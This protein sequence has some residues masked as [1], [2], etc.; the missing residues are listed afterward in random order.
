MSSTEHKNNDDTQECGALKIKNIPFSEVLELRWLNKVEVTAWLS[1]SIRNVKNK[2]CKTHQKEEI[3]DN[4]V[5]ISPSAILFHVYLLYRSSSFGF[6]RWTAAAKII[7]YRVNFAAWQWNIL[8]CYNYNFYKVSFD[9]K[10]KK[11]EIVGSKNQ[12]SNKENVSYCSG[13]HVV[14]EGTETPPIY[15]L[16][17]TTPHQNLGSPNN[18]KFQKSWKI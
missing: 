2:T 7:L 6:Q 11:V 9:Q 4:N 3:S 13:Q 16:A 5:R 12:N 17:V 10:H 1:I 18:R 15:C 8:I 14:H